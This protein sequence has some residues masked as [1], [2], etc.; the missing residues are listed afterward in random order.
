MEAKPKI[1]ELIGVSASGK[2]TFA[3]F[4]FSSSSDYDNIETAAFR[5]LLYHQDIKIPCKSLLKLVPTR[6]AYKLRL[7][8]ICDLYRDQ[9]LAKSKNPETSKWLEF[10]LKSTSDVEDFTVAKTILITKLIK[11]ITDYELIM[12]PVNN[13]RIILAD[14]FFL[15]KIF[16]LQSND[17][18]VFELLGM[19][20]Y[21]LDLL[22]KFEVDADLSLER[23]RQRLAGRNSDIRQINN[24]KLLDRIK[25]S[26]HTTNI[27]ES[28]LRNKNVKTFVVNNESNNKQILSKLK[29][30]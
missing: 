28:E 1:I 2:S 14:E 12:S 3:D 26:Q 27:I 7:T 8:K 21:D 23:L 17:D 4:V 10:A 9:L 24:E 30:I 15:Q 18:E 6:L 16:S 20:N 29:E 22:L 5:G 25:R 11:N 13:G 19:I